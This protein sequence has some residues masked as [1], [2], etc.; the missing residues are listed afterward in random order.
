MDKIYE[1]AQI[2]AEQN[3]E[4]IYTLLSED[5]NLSEINFTIEIVQ[6]MLNY[7]F[8]IKL[9]DRDHDITAATYPSKKN[10]YFK[11]VSKI[12][13]QYGYDLPSFYQ[14]PNPTDLKQKIDS[15]LLQIT[16]NMEQRSEFW[17]ILTGDKNSPNK[18]YTV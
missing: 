17:K 8:L 7:V 18:K 9:I 15:L 5:L 6:E 14:F 4:Y 3:S 12:K 1:Q 10:S 11:L 2:L 16:T 13:K